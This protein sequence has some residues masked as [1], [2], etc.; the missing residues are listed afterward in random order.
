MRAPNPRPRSRARYPFLATVVLACMLALPGH[1][2]AAD[3][4]PRLQ[5][6]VDQRAVVQARLD[7]L[8]Q[9]MS[10][11]EA[12]IEDLEGRLATLE[13]QAREQQARA[14]EAN[15]HLA[16]RIRESYIKGTVDPTI[17]LLTSSSAEEARE[18]ARLLGSLAVRSR[19]DKERA[20]AERT[21]VVAAAGEVEFVAGTLRERQAQLDEAR[22]EVS[23]LLAEAE[24]EVQEV[25]AVLA[26][27]QRAREE[28]ERREREQRERELA[29]RE[30]AARERAGRSNSAQSSSSAGGAAQSSAPAPAGVACPVGGPRSYSDSWGAARSGGRRHKGTDILAPRGTAIYAYESGTVTRLWNSRLGGISLYLRGNSGNTYFYTHLQGYV[31]GIS[32]GQRVQV[33]QHIAFNGDTGNARGIPHLHFEV[34]PGGGANVNPYPYVARACG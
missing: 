4:D 33:G 18:Q 32:G 19:G 10:T 6:V 7:D 11:L 22:Q 12:E 30:R 31:G 25:R 3:T 23:T 14:A 1:G 34:M 26:A 21:R 8:L 9:R 28:R 29:A 24:A 27:E 16:A 15:G 20:S 17:A 2:V 5:K 13:A